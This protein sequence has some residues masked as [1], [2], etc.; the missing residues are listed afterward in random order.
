MNILIIV[1]ELAIV[2]V[3]FVNSTDSAVFFLPPIHTISASFASIFAA[4]APSDAPRTLLKEIK[5]V[6]LATKGEEV[7]TVDWRIHPENTEISSTAEK[8]IS[9]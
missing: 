9:L 6:K 4:S 7:E 3:S 5:T 8:K 2:I 1:L